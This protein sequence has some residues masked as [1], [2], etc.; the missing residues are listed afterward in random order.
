MFSRFKQLMYGGIFRDPFYNH[1]DRGEWCKN[2]SPNW[3]KYPATFVV[4]FYDVFFNL[5][6]WRA[7]PSD[8]VYCTDLK[9]R[10]HWA[11]FVLGAFSLLL[12]CLQVLYKI[13][14]ESLIN[15][16]MPCH[17]SVMLVAL[18]SFSSRKLYWAYNWMISM[19]F[20]CLV[21][22]IFPGTTATLKGP[23]EVE[24]FYIEHLVPFVAAVVY[25]SL[26]FGDLRWWEVRIHQLGFSL[27]SFYERAICFPLSELTWVNVNFALCGQEDDPFF[28]PLGYTY[29]LLIDVYINFG[30][31][32]TKLALL[33]PQVGVKKLKKFFAKI[34]KQI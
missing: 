7:I 29:Y 20:G 34:K 16:F 22:L 18:I 5:K 15:M 3:F 33:S 2:F 30:C 19:L 27:F 17:L 21:A 26:L 8:P 4:I 12:V 11:E 1:M 14:S 13:A 25:Y 9:G 32:L 10:R 28:K 6:T 24:V 31:Y 23:F